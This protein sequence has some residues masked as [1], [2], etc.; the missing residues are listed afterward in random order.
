M[1]DT[2]IAT[3]FSIASLSEIF[4]GF[5]LEKQQL[6]QAIG[7]GNLLKLLP[8]NKFPRQLALWVLRNMD[9]KTAEIEV[10]KGGKIKMEEYDVELVLG[11][12]RKCK[13]VNCALQATEMEIA[14]IRKIMMLNNDT[15]ITV[16]CVEEILKRDYGSKMTTREKEAFKVAFLLCADAYFLAP[17]GGKAKINLEICNNL[18]NPSMI[19]EY[20]WCEYVM[21]S[22]FKGSRRV[23]QSL[24]YCKKTVTLEGCLLLGVVSSNNKIGNA[25]SN[26]SSRPENDSNMQFP[27]ACRF[28]T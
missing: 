2:K 24:E 20:N 6:V 27:L 28:F 21:R 3:S 10:V 19:G 11:L 17:K 22:L 25:C 15:E 8:T 13:V 14:R 12:P 4:S 1:P 5:D 18:G 16:D 9:H 7:F 26:L 23:Q